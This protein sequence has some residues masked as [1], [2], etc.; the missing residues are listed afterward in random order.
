MISKSEIEQAFHEE[1]FN[2][3]F[4]ELHSGDYERIV[5]IISK[6]SEK[7]DSVLSC[8]HPFKR[9]HQVGTILFCNKCKKTL[10]E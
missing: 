7:A 4:V 1:F 8:E 3:R 9:L 2:G 6:L 10:K 5:E